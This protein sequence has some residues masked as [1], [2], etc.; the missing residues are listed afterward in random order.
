MR[1]ILDSLNIERNVHVGGLYNA[2]NFALTEEE[3]TRAKEQIHYGITLC[4]EISSTLISIR[5]PFFAAKDKIREELLSKTKT[6]FLKLLKEEV[7]FASRNQVKIA[8]ESFCYHPFI[9]EGLYDF[10][11]FVSK[12]PLEKPGILLDIGHVYQM[13]IDLFEAVHLFK[14]RLLDIH[15]TKEL[16]KSSTSPYR[17]RNNKFSRFHKSFARG[18]I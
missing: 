16:Q 14:F 9:F 5:P 6:R 8:L 10:V 4:K 11:Q 15:V 2:R 7:N 13:G 17:K 18:R 3:F 12:F 1:R